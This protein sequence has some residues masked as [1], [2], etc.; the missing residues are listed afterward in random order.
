L[1]GIHFLAGF[2]SGFRVNKRSPHPLSA[3]R[4]TS[5]HLPVKTRDEIQNLVT[6]H[7]KRRDAIENHIHEEESDLFSTRKNYD[8]I[9]QRGGGATKLNFSG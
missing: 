8:R 4:L 7:T 2:P 9:P 3:R 5:K 1:S 6:Y